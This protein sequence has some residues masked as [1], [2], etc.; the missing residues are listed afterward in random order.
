MKRIF[1]LTILTLVLS[2]NGVAQK[3]TRPLTLSD[4]LWQ[5]LY[6]AL[7]SEDW[8]VA[9]KLSSKYMDELSAEGTD[10]TLP[11]L[12]YMFLYS[13]AGKISAGKMSYDELEKRIKGFAGKQIFL[14]A[15]Y[16]VQNCHVPADFNALCKSDGAPHDIMVTSANRA[17][18]TIHAFEYIRLKEKFDWAKTE[19][20]IASI[21]GTIESIAPN[22]NKSHILIMRIFVIDAVIEIK[23][24]P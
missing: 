10:L 17:A 3:A 15:R 19:G 6:K 13:A 21:T 16:L 18:T 22:P 9:E 8:D 23:G 5:R 4:T 2:L 1:L 7:D 11:R 12:R 20:R 14:P 24:L